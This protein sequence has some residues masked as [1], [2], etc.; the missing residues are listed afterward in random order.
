MGY[1][2]SIPKVSWRSGHPNTPN[3]NPNF[4]HTQYTNSEYNKGNHFKIY[5]QHLK[6]SKFDAFPPPKKN[7]WVPL[8]NHLLYLKKRL[9]LPAKGPQLRNH[10]SKSHQLMA[11]CIWECLVFIFCS[12]GPIFLG[13]GY[14]GQFSF[15]FRRWVCVSEGGMI[16]DFRF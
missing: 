7:G 2:M 11:S 16:C 9:T 5:Q 4:T 13:K 10:P 14:V 12:T 1:K 3:K 6:C 15:S 8:K